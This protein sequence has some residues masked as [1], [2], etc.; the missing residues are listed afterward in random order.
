MIRTTVNYADLVPGA[1]RDKVK[2]RQII[3][4]LTEASARVQEVYASIP[5]IFDL[6]RAIGDQLDV[7]GQWVGIGRTIPVEV[8]GVYFEWDGGAPVGWDAGIWQGIF[9]PDA[10]PV[11]LND[12]D[13]RRLIRTKILIN[14]WD[15][16]LGELEAIWQSLLP[17]GRPGI[18]LD[19]QDMTL[20]FGFEGTPITGLQLAILEIG[21]KL[22]KPAAVRIL[23]VFSATAGQPLFAWDNGPGWDNSSWS[24]LLN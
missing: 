7:I 21:L 9:D 3:Q 14:T 17:D 6:D 23:D 11:L 8:S 1:N 2:F 10:G 20:S 22:I 13:Y 12:E 15:G 18:V 5:Q 4:L 24:T 16:S 19:N